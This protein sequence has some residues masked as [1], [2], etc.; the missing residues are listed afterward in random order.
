MEDSQL[1]LVRS[2]VGA[3]DA[4][5]RLEGHHEKKILAN[6]LFLRR[7]FF[8]TMMHEGEDVLEHITSSRLWRSSS[9][10]LALWPARRI[11]DHASW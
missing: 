8:T 5:S 10:R 11:G 2:V 9:M 3:N 1:S 4:W 7:R 6:K